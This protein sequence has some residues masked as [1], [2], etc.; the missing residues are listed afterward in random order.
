M[1]Q[2]QPLQQLLHPFR[3]AALVDTR[4]AG[5]DCELV[6]D[7]RRDELVGRLLEDRPDP[8]GEVPGPPPVRLRPLP[9]GQRPVGGQRAGGRCGQPAQREREGRLAGPVRPDDRGAGARPQGEVDSLHGRSL[10]V[11]P[12]HRDALRAEQDVARAR[13]AAGYP[14]RVLRHPDPVPSQL[15]TVPLEHVVRC[16]VRA[17]PS[18]RGQDDHPVHPGQP[19]TDPVL[20][21]DA[22]RAGAGEQPAHLLPQP[23]RTGRVEHRGRLV[24]QQQPRTQREH[25]REGETL[26]LAAGQPRRRVRTWV[27]EADRGQRLVDPRPDL[28]GRHG[29]VLQAER[30]VVAAAGEHRLRERV[31]QQQAGAGAPGPDSLGARPA[32]RDVVEQQRPLLVTGL[33]VEQTGEPLQQG[34]LAGAA[35]PEQEDALPGG[36]VE[37]QAPDRPGLTGAVAP[38]PAPGAQR[39]GRDG[40]APARHS[41]LGT[42]AGQTRLPSRPEA[43]GASTPVRASARVRAHE[44]RPAMSRPETTAQAM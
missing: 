14:G 15:G 19:R 16:T 9:G 7:G 5:T 39:D 8:G 25:P 13:T 38:A 2:P 4:A 35:G 24:E 34:G 42:A 21:E 31:L 27:G 26:A 40:C 22:R 28:P 18:A 43:S 41:G 10:G 11:R 29:V 36:H 23:C 6:G 32:R 30:H 37:V 3:R 20:H 17:H 1:L 12:G 33:G 44:P